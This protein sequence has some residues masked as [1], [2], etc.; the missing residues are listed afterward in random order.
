MGGEA[1]RGN[2]MTPWI[3]FVIG[4]ILTFLMRGSFLLFGDRISL[5]SWTDAPL[6]YVGPAAFAAITVPATLGDD[7]LA[8][9]APPSAEVYGIAA[10]I[11]VVW[12]TRNIPLCLVV[13]LIVLWIL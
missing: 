7:G 9:L 12:K 2:A 13:S 11:L 4:G 1:I 3:V 10:A 6:R 5:P 8:N